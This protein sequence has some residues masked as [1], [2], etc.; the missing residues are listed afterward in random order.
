MVTLSTINSAGSLGN[1]LLA[2]FTVLPAIAVAIF[3]VRRWKSSEWE[4][5]ARSRGEALQDARSDLA[6]ERRERQEEA[7]QL[8]SDN[9]RLRERVAALEAEV[10]SLRERTDVR[11]L[12]TSV[13]ALTKQMADLAPLVRETHM[14]ITRR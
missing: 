7:K 5:L 12:A 9:A 10:K 13:D 8:R 3:A 6:D 4:S 11:P 2:L 14:M 1:V